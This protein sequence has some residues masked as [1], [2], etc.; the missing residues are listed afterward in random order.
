M[1]DLMDHRDGDLVDDLILRVAGV[2][3]RLAVDRDG[4]RQRSGV[5]GAALG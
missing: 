1:G 2:Q 3:Q 5:V 4:I